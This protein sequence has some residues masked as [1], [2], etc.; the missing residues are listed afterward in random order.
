MKNKSY[1]IKT[2]FIKKMAYSALIQFMIF[3]LILI[4][5]KNY[6]QEQLSTFSKNLIINDSF[7]TDEIG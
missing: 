5:A 1:S 7:T 4:L 6:F 2:I 3:G